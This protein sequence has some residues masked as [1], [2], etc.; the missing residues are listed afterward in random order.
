MTP[1]KYYFLN[2]VVMYEIMQAVFSLPGFD[3]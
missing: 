3:E 1:V 2:V